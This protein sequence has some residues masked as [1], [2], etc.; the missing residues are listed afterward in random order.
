MPRHYILHYICITYKKK[1]VAPCAFPSSYELVFPPSNFLMVNLMETVRGFASFRDGSAEGALQ[2][3]RDH[4]S[5]FAAI[6]MAEL[7]KVKKDR[8]HPSPLLYSILSG[9]LFQFCSLLLLYDWQ[10]PLLVDPT[11]L[12]SLTA[13]P[14][15]T[16]ST[17]QQPARL[18]FKGNLLKIWAFLVEL[19]F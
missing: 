18:T 6:D 1:H 19:G 15:R 13:N 9:F 12:T 8:G 7:L 4:I 5:W 16:T 14:K 3:P 2:V 17:K 11:P 10:V